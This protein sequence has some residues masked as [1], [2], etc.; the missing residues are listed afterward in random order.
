MIN[1]ENAF[2]ELV[3]KYVKENMTKLQQTSFFVPSFVKGMLVAG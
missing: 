3:H 2:D 1:L